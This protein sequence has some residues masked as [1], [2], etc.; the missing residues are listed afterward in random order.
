[1]KRFMSWRLKLVI[2]LGMT[3]F[4]FG[5]SE[6]VSGPSTDFSESPRMDNV[7]GNVMRDTQEYPADVATKWFN[8]TYALVKT[9]RWSPPLASRLWGY[10]GVALYEAVR[11]GMRGARSLGGQLNDFS[12]VSFPAAAATGYHWPGVANA[13]LHTVVLELFRGATPATI[14]R[15]NDQ[16]KMLRDAYSGSITFEELRLSESYG[17]KVGKVILEWA[18]RDGYQQVYDCSWTP[19]VGDGYSGAD[20]SR[21]RGATPAMLGATAD[22]CGA[23]RRCLRSRSTLAVF[24]AG[25]IGV[26]P[27][28]S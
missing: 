19:P 24:G 12:E 26:L 3:I 25:R 17:A 18:R 6:E 20:P 16:Y 27:G 11:P 15:I 21:I 22:L 5:C 8:L 1:M 13:T 4:Q 7:V 2:P 23:G 28:R 14:A 9:E 10:T